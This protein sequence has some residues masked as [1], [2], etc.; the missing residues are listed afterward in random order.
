MKIC[1]LGDFSANLDE[2]FKNISH[3]FAAGLE[4]GNDLIRIDIKQLWE[5]VF[6]ESIRHAQP[7]LIHTIAQPTEQSLLFTKILQLRWPSARTVVSALCPERFFKKG[8]ISQRQKLFAQFTRP[9]LVLIQSRDAQDRFESLAYFVKYLPNG[10][11]LHRFKP[12]SKSQKL[13]LRRKYRLSP[14]QPVVL[15]VGHLETARNLTALTALPVNN[16]QIVIVGSNYLGVDIKLLEK[17]QDAGFIVF[18]GYHSHIEELYMLADCYVFPAKPGDSISMPLSVLE[19]MACNL[20]VVTTCFEGLM[21]FF[22]Q[23]PSFE[24]IND[25]DDLLDSIES[26]LY[27]SPPP[28]T[29][30]MVSAYSWD[31]II[32]QLENYYCELSA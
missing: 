32:N 1:L 12:A 17:L 15:H 11:D 16:I 4:A 24:Y 25:P 5:S 19:A 7:Q 29:R 2:G 6:W 13:Y 26:V 8:A 3:H 10:V 31:S 14:H 20:P 9:D 30:D 23:S 18:E 22:D 27:S 28:I 21:N